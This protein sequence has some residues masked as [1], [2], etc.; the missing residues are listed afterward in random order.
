MSNGIMGHISHVDQEAV[1]QV[2]SSLEILCLDHGV[3]FIGIPTGSSDDYPR[4]AT[5]YTW[6][7]GY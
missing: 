4:W 1:R 7:K 2:P 3:D 5:M 6:G